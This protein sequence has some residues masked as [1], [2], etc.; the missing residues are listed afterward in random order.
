MILVTQG[1]TDEWQVLAGLAQSGDKAAYASL[2]RDIAPFIK[3]FLFSR[4]SQHDAVDDITQEILISVHKSLKTYDPAMPFK[5]WL[6]AIVNFRKIDYLR[7]HYGH[8]QNVTKSL[9]QEDFL[10]WPVT[11]MAHAGEY[12]DIEGALN[13]LPDGQRKLF[14]MVKIE[15]YTAKEAAN[16]TGM[17][18][19]AV[20]VSVH[21]T[22]KKLMDIIGKE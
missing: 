22:Q 11:N 5:P 10:E 4:L 1:G 17:K 21:R 3:K 19:S 16:M 20:K 13:T 6:M 15:G 8:R 14:T 2:L 7:Q 12:K 18:E 9:D